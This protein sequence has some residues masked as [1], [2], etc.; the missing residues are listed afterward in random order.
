MPV[1][2]EAFLHACEHVPAD[3]IGARALAWCIAWS[4][5]HVDQAAL[6]QTAGLSFDRVKDHWRTIMEGVPE[7]V[8]RRA[9]ADQRAERARQHAQAAAQG[10]WGL[11]RTDAPGIAAHAPSI[12]NHA[13]G[14]P[15]GDAPSMSGNAPS[16]KKDA[17][18]IRDGPP[19]PLIENAPS[20]DPHAPG[21]ENH[22]PSM[23]ARR[24]RKEGGG[25]EDGFTHPKPKPSLQNP[26]GARRNVWTPESLDELARVGVGA[27]RILDDLG[28]AEPALSQLAESEAV[29]T[30]AIIETAR[31]VLATKGPVTSRPGLLVAR[32]RKAFGLPALRAAP[33]KTEARKA[34]QGLAETIRRRKGN[35]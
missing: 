33:L 35:P 6:A 4:G 21:I 24:V 7:L 27:Y 19:P 13:P 15:D 9:Q 34:A 10:R 20:I 11:L 8:R 18:G 29:P 23:A 22:A 3:I 32:L 31:A 2:A 16:I 30:A 14:I 28:V 12:P 17:P 26:Q 5:G 25:G 1:D